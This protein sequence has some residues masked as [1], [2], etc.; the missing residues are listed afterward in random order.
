MN[1]DAIVIIVLLAI[2]FFVYDT[3]K[4]EHKTY[5]IINKVQEKILYDYEVIK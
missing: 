1:K 3:N 2:L 4:V 5:D